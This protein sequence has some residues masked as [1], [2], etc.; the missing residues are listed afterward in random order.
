MRLIS[1]PGGLSVPLQT[2]SP[3][4]EATVDIVDAIDDRY[5]RYL[6]A[7]DLLPATDDV[8]LQVLTST[9]NGTSF[10]AGGSDYRFTTRYYDSTAVDLGR[11]GNPG[12]SMRLA[13]DTATASVGNDSTGGIVGEFKVYRRGNSS[14]WSMFQWE[15]TYLSANSRTISIYG[16]GIRE[17][18]ATINALR[19]SF[20]SGNVAS[21]NVAIYGLLG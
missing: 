4:V 2:Y 10:D 3:S 14:L 11:Q 13:E 7:F 1:A 8:E 12:N 20:E 19:F 17:E 18:T 16:S 15:A 9:D 6:V 5:R 21:G